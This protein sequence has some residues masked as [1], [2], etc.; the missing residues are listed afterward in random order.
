MHGF[1]RRWAVLLTWAVV[2]LSPVAALAQY[3]ATDGEWRS[4]GGDLG[5][6]KYSPLD[7][8][9]AANFSRLRLA[10]RWESADASLDLEALRQQLPR[11]RIRMFQATP[12]MAGGV[13]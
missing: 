3:G 4:Y 8:I 2:L 9:D 7:Q 11:V 6:T 1:S 13:L 10:W 12:L 5:S